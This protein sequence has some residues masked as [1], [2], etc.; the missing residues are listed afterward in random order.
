ML[1]FYSLLNPRFPFSSSIHFFFANGKIHA[2]MH[3]V[4][5]SELKEV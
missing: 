3:F 1:F 2:I 4:L 5:F